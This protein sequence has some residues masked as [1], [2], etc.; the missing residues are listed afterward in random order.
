M[1]FLMVILSLFLSDGIADHLLADTEQTREAILEKAKISIQSR[2]DEDH[3]RFD[4]KARWIPG[5][6]MNIEPESIVDVQPAGPI[7]R[8][9]IFDV[10]YKQRSQYETVQ[11]QLIVDKEYKIPV[12]VS[13]IMAGEKL[14]AENL[15]LKWV[16]VPYNRSQWVGSIE[17]LQGK[18]LRRSLAPGQPVRQIDVTTNYV[19]H[20]GDPVTMIYEENGIHIGIK[21][22]ARENGSIGDEIKIFCD[23][24]RKR[25][26]GKVQ[27]PGTVIWKKTL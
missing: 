1:L 3:H 27:S 25:Y 12:A 9:T 16:S 17:E 24:T 19:I 8:N 23:E 4:V 15:E 6:L 13:R 21:T 26:V 22:E 14:N 7:E 11:V 18:T 2:F 5:S 20:A 10:T